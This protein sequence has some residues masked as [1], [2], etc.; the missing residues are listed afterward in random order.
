MKHRL[1]CLVL[2][3]AVLSAWAVPVTLTPSDA[4]AV[5]ESVSL[6]EEYLEKSTGEKPLVAP[7]A[8]GLN[9]RL[10]VRAAMS[11]EPETFILEFPAKNQVVI[12]GGTPLAVRHGTCEFLE[13]FYGIRW[14][15]SG[16]DGEYVPKVTKTPE[17]PATS[18]RMSP[19][20]KIRTFALHHKMKQDYVWAARN[21]GIFNY[22]FFGFPGYTWFHHNMHRLLPV[23]KY[24]ETHPEFFPVRDGKRLIPEKGNTVY[25]QYCSTTWLMQLR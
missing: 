24:A 19:V 12:A 4:K 23:E 21:K 3:C 2:M 1:W 20:Y 25:W 10:E 22:D 14:L 17:F 7:A 18:I 13:R 11:A 16:P 5:K 6:L 9:I 8:E 15:Y